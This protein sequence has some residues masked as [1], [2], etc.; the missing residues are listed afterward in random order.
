[1]LIT[2]LSEILLFDCDLLA[3]KDTGNLKLRNFVLA[4]CLLRAIQMSLDEDHLTNTAR[5]PD[6]RPDCSLPNFPQVFYRFPNRSLTLTDLLRIFL[7]QQS[8]PVRLDIKTDRL[9]SP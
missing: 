8:L 3:F 5:E 7:S 9:E 4:N 1:M 2:G 6:S